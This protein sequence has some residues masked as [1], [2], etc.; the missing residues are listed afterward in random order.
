LTGSSAYA[1]G[2]GRECD[3]GDVSIPRRE[4]GELVIV[5]EIADEGIGVVC[6]H[7]G[8]DAD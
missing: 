2:Q 8:H 7:M 4:G 6:V 3:V 1:E 5:L